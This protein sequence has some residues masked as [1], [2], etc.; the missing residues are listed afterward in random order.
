MKCEW[1][2]I[3]SYCSLGIIAMVGHGGCS[4]KSYLADPGNIPH[5]DPLC[6]NLS[7]LHFKSVTIEIVP[8]TFTFSAG[9]PSHSDQLL[10]ISQCFDHGQV[11]HHW[12]RSTN[13]GQG[14]WSI[15]SETSKFKSTGPVSKWF[16]EVI[17]VT[18][19]MYMV[20]SW[21]LNTGDRLMHSWNTVENAL[22]AD[23][24]SERAGLLTLKVLNFWT[25]TL[26]ME[27]LV[28]WQ[29]L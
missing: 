19:Q 21:S 2:K 25:F 15:I 29:L 24:W 9:G 3:Y 1:V 26:D 27:W 8:S 10:T 6:I 23:I 28:L 14:Q 22:L 4:P 7:W 17:N 13:R 20:Y 18:V 11:C 5:P 12:T 16:I